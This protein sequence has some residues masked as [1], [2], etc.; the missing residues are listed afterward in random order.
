MS[1][2][3]SGLSKIYLLVFGS[4]MLQKAND[5]LL[6]FTLRARG[7]NNFT[8]A[9]VSGEQFFVSKVLS[10]MD[11]KVCIDVGANVG[12]YSLR[13]LATTN[14]RVYAFEPLSEPFSHLTKLKH[15]FGERLVAVN[16]GVGSKDEI[17]TMHFNPAATEHAS[18]SVEAKDV[19]YVRNQ[20]AQDIEVVMLDTFF[21]DNCDR[22]G[23]DF[24]KIDTEGF[25]Y[26][27]LLGAQRTIARHKPKMIQIE[28]NW[29]Q[30]FKRRTLYS[31]ATLLAGYQ[32]FQMLPNR[33][34]RREP[35]DPYSNIY[36]FSNFVF[37]R[38]DLV[39]TV[40]T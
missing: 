30:L 20:L 12:T 39:H 14:A 32:V 18:F 15:K 7:Y 22:E 8:D 26:E 34:V 2:L 37:V 6:A 13:L 21:L 19:P 38:D 4:R 33:L 23:L 36:L 10:R 24:L 25:E 17:L 29:H 28:Y 31:F 3:V 5:A 35:K 16:K 1:V 9:R 27:V 40:E 11:P